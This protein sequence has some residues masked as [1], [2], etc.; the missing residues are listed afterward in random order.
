MLLDAKYCIYPTVLDSFLAYKEIESK[1]E[2]DLLA[3]INR[4]GRPTEAMVRGTAFND[5]ID[6]ICAGKDTNAQEGFYVARKADYLPEDVM[7]E[8]EVDKGFVPLFYFPSEIVESFATLYKQSLRQEYLYSTL[9]TRYGNVYLYGF[10]DG[11]FPF[12]IRDI[13]TTGQYNAQKYRNHL[14]AYIYTYCLRQMGGSP[15]GFW[16]DVTDMKSIWH[17][18]YSAENLHLDYIVNTCEDFIEW[19][20]DR[21]HLITRKNLFNQQQDKK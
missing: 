16:Y 20:E 13:K 3:D 5:I 15:K 9:H 10:A 14:Q 19:I 8:L 17:E 21:R 6:A 7:A 4:T 1:T 12:E 2:A 11:V 18:Y